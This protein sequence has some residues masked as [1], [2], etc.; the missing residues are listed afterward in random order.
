M[1]KAF[2]PYWSYDIQKTETWLSAMAERGYFLEGLNRSTRTFSFRQGSPKSITYRIGY[3]KVKGT[4]LPRSLVNEGWQQVLHTGNW[5]FL[6]NELPLEQ[7]KTSP[8]REGIVKR[9]RIH[10]YIFA[11]IVLYFTFLL[12][13]NL[14]MFA[15]TLLE[16]VPVEVVPSPMWAF[17]YTAFALAVVVYILCLYQILLIYKTN[18][19][20]LNGHNKKYSRASMNKEDEREL[21]RSGQL[22]VKRKFGWMYSPD[23][24]EEWLEA[25]EARGYNLYRVSRTGTAFYFTIGNPRNVRYCAD[26]QNM[27][28]E[29]YFTMH[30]DAG[31][32]SVFMSNSVLTKWTIWSREYPDAEQPPQ[33]YSDKSHRLKHAKRIAITHT[34]IFLPIVIMYL[35]NIVAFTT[36]TA[37]NGMTRLNLFNTVMFIICIIIFGSFTVRTWLFYWRL[38]RTYDF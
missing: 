17:T 22:V 9:N 31:W 3:D 37:S 27:A 24:L 18:K 2:R 12:V 34:V 33:L 25:M 29:N 38:R 10:T 30:R 8:V 4:S 35:F 15:F 19:S 32:T 36:Y 14:S 13:F 28:N 20:L 26:Y 6:A 11:G 5:D 16:D 1:K 23:R 21:K 7:I